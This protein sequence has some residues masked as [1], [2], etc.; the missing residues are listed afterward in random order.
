MRISQKLILGFIG[1]A[2]LVGVVGAI[3]IK[4]NTEIV[5][6]VDR[7][8]LGNS[9]EAK[10]ATET[11]YLIQR[12]Q[13]SI[14]ELLSEAID[15]RPKRKKYA[16]GAITN[17]TSKLQQFNLLWEDAIKLGIELSKEEKIEELKAFKNLKIKIDGLILLVVL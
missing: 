13:A 14:N 5:F 4:Y 2:S 12:I 9:N 17:S 10:A 3:A 1:I 6:D 7:I 8:L 16:K 11:V 15:G